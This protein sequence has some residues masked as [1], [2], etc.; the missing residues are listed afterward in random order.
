MYFVYI[1][2]SRS[3]G[4]YYVGQTENIMA[5]LARHNAGGANATRHGGPWE[6]L[7]ARA[8]ETRAEAMRE[9]KRIKKLKSRRAIEQL[10]ASA[11][12]EWLKAPR[13]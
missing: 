9:E 11:P 12:A 3:T 4:R 2:R 6:L 1:L 10:L 8:F 7:Y 5:R 13:C